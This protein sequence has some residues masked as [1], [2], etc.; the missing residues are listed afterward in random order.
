MISKPLNP[1]YE[2]IPSTTTKAILQP[3]HV[4]QA[5]ELTINALTEKG[6]EIHAHFGHWTLIESRFSYDGWY[7]ATAVN[8]D[9]AIIHLKVVMLAQAIVPGQQNVWRVIEKAAEGWQGETL[10]SWLVA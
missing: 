1:R 10:R 8:E 3:K 2:S 6:K 9:G 4:D 7:E 5:A